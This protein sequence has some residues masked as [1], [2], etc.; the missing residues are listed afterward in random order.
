MQQMEHIFAP[1]RSAL[2]AHPY[3]LPDLLEVIGGFAQS[4]GQQHIATAL[5]FHA[6][7][8]IAE[9]KGNDVPY[10]ALLAEA[11]RRTFFDNEKAAEYKTDHIL[12]QGEDAMRQFAEYLIG[13]IHMDATQITSGTVHTSARHH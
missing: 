4:E 6:S 10:N 9:N 11:Y 5:S 13:S 3:T 2:L 7:D 12:L 8:F 1:L